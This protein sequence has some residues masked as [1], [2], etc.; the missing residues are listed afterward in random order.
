[1]LK[2]EVSWVAAMAGVMLTLVVLTLTACGRTSPE[3]EFLKTLK[4]GWNLGNTLESHRDGFYSDDPADFET[5]WENSVTTKELILFVKASGFNSIRI[6]VTWEPHMDESYSV[7]ERWMDRVAE[8][9]DYAYGE[10][11]YVIINAH[12]DRWYIPSAENEARAKEVMRILWKQIALRFAEYDERLLFESMNEPRLIGT[13]HEWTP[14]TAEAQRIV[15]ELNEV[16]VKTVRECG[17]NN[18][19]RYLVLPTYGANS[20][21][22]AI[23]AFRLPEG[24]KHLIAS[25]HFYNP[26]SFASAEGTHARWSRD[27]PEDTEQ[28]NRTIRALEHHFTGKGIPAMVGEFGAAD[29][30]NL[31]A[32]LDWTSYITEKA[33]QSNIVCFWWDPGGRPAHPHAYSIINRRSLSVR[34]T[35]IQEVLTQD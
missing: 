11:M 29:K 6:P 31:S 33:R 18:A 28:I 7:D 8:I 1:M 2:R 12:H 3:V 21:P 23:E 4:A 26:H 24:E 15:N 17:G 10:G 5:L 13:A 35:E 22:E 20:K 16:F 30:G 32:R 34:F 19:G 27:I 14:G 25:V 9:V